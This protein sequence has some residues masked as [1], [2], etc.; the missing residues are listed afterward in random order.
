MLKAQPTGGYQIS[1]AVI[2]AEFD[3]RIA[4]MEA[5]AALQGGYIPHPAMIRLR[6]TDE[7]LGVLVKT[8]G[9]PQ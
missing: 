7:V 8:P 1:W 5:K 4:E 3:Y 9:V 6:L 2:T